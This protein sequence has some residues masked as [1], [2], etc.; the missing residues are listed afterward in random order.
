MP[1]SKRTNRTSFVLRSKKPVECKKRLL[2]FSVSTIVLFVI[3]CKNITYRKRF[4]DKRLDTIIRG[5]SRKGPIILYGFSMIRGQSLIA[6]LRAGKES[7]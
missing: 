2:R 3:V 1:S 6:Q 5:V 4:L 7:R